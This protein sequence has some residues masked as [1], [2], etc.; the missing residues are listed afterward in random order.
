M[1]F[2]KNANIRKR[3]RI[4]IL[5]HRSCPVCNNNQ[6]ERLDAYSTKEWGLVSCTQCSFVYLRNPPN[7]E[8]L[9]EELSWEKLY[10]QKKSNGGSTSLSGLARRLRSL[11][12]RQGSSRLER[13]ALKWFG[14]GK[15][16]D[17]GCGT[18]IRTQAPII[19]FGIEISTAM[20]AEV[21]KEMRTRGGYCMH[22][23][24]A[25]GVWN[26]GASYFDGAILHSYLEHEADP[27]RVLS[28]LHRCLKPGAKVFVRV[29]NYGSLNRRVVGSKWCGFRHPDHVNYFNVHSLRKMSQ[30]NG[31]SVEV[32]N[33]LTLC[34][35]DNINALLTKI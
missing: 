19:P 20:H 24:G 3:K 2:S 12:H 28:G 7:Y 10:V 30:N 32:L 25:D 16:L 27:N 11:T 18:I 17:V 5:S 9:E 34:F 4:S 15:V 35:D 21:D 29:P 22:A 14:S 26:F 8:A 13:N 31:L 23:A 6:S 1:S 33:K